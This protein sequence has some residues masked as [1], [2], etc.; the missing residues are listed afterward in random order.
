VRD[1]NLLEFVVGDN[2]E[3]S[4]STYSGALLGVQK[5]FSPSPHLMVKRIKR[6]SVIDTLKVVS[7]YH[8][9]RVIRV[10]QDE[11]QTPGAD[12]PKLDW[13]KVED[14][15]IFMPKEE[16]GQP[17][18]IQSVIDR[19][20]KAPRHTLTPEQQAAAGPRDHAWYAV[21]P[22]S[23][24]EL[25][26]LTPGVEWMLEMLIAK[27]LPLIGSFTITEVV[28]N[29]ADRKTEHP[30]IGHVLGKVQIN[31]FRYANTFIKGN[32]D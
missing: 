17:I 25:V 21:F 24:F 5:F 13:K 32:V 7:D 15:K 9:P 28:E 30:R 27:R 23:S 29:Y 16:G 26:N 12:L 11:L 14:V 3:Q 1:G 4:Y 31:W 2:L 10:S 18:Q 8:L 22:N 20:V 19:L 6:G